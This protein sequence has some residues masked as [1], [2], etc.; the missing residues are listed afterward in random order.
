MSI[1]IRGDRLCI[2]VRAVVRA[3]VGHLTLC[4]TARRA[5]HF[6]VI[7]CVIANFQGTLYVSDVIIIGRCRTADRNVVI[8]CRLNGCLGIQGDLYRES[9]AV[10]KPLNS[11]R[12]LVIAIHTDDLIICGDGDIF[13]SDAYVKTA[14]YTVKVVIV[15]FYSVIYRIFP[16]IFAHWQIGA[17]A[18]SVKTELPHAVKSLARGYEDLIATAVN[19][20]VDRRRLAIKFSLYLVHHDCDRLGACRLI[21]AVCHNACDNAVGS[22]VHGKSRAA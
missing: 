22:C 7:I 12:Q 21:I 10:G 19:K 15:P 11:I 17:P 13:L 3:G 4:I 9:F 16:C 20:S 6:P 14:H 18:C 1:L 2:S 5:G 8:P